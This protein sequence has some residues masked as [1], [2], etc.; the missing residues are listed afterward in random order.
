MPS[1][2]YTSKELAEVLQVTTRTLDYWRLRGAGPDF[3][4]LA[5]NAIRYRENDVE[6]W[7]KS[8]KRQSRAGQ[9]A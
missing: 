3:V 5:R 6:E 8:R 4:V 2:L 7:L 1:K 9:A